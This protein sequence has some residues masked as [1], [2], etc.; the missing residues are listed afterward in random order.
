MKNM[1][2]MEISE[3]TNFAVKDLE[4]KNII[5][6]IIDDVI[7]NY[8]NV[9]H[10]LYLPADMGSISWKNWLNGRGGIFAKDSNMYFKGK[11]IPK[12]VLL[13]NS[14][15]KIIARLIRDEEME[16]FETLKL[17]NGKIKDKFYMVLKKL[18]KDEKL[19]QSIRYIE[20][21]EEDMDHDPKI[22]IT[23]NIAPLE[24]EANYSSH[25]LLEE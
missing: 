5:P 20:E 21:K 17:I 3:D 19:T 8:S 1:K 24:D 9:N 13:E 14:E 11:A 2:N 23:N 25:N 18:Q 7:I 15:E 4:I 22:L 6:N 12:Y 16:A 10:E